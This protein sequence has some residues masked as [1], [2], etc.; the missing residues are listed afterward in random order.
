M[1]A[2]HWR[3]LQ[4]G[5]SSWHRWRLITN[6]LSWK[7]T[8]DWIDI[9]SKWLSYIVGL[10]VGSGVVRWCQ[11]VLNFDIIMN[12]D[13]TCLLAVWCI[14]DGADIVPLTYLGEKKNNKKKRL[15][16]SAWRRI[17]FFFIKN[18]RFIGLFVVS[19]RKLLVRILL[20][21]AIWVFFVVVFVYFLLDSA[22]VFH[23]QRWKAENIFKSYMANLLS[24]FCTLFGCLPKL[25][26]KTWIVLYLWYCL[27]IVCPCCIQNESVPTNMHV[28]CWSQH[29]M[30]DRQTDGQAKYKSDYIII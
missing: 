6:S 8:R 7:H 26:T 20:F 25:C 15:H 11:I 18:S 30:M 22:T 9:I 12:S 24:I 5:Q 23:Q 17:G 28:L 3:L 14:C 4:M 19:P 16:V 29:G 27:Y 10:L 13:P 1:W 21:Q 2:R